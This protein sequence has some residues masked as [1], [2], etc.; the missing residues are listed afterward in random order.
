MEGMYYR[1]RLKGMS[2]IGIEGGG[3]TTLSL[4]CTHTE[5][6][7]GVSGHEGGIQAP[8]FVEVP[9]GVADGPKAQE[10]GAFQKTPL[11]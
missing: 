6:S 10:R 4:T 1:G 7:S 8:P 11:R 3:V 9:E 5:L 2:G